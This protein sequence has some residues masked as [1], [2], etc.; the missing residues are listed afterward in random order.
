MGRSAV[1]VRC[2]H[3]W[4]SARSS[5]AESSVEFGPDTLHCRGQIEF[6]AAKAARGVVICGL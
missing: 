6:P 1:S 4:D 2:Q 3:L 5:G